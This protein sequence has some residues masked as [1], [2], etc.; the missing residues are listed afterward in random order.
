MERYLTAARVVS[1]LGGRQPA[2]GRRPRRSTACRP[3]LQQH[4]RND[5]L[6]F[7]TR[8]GTLIRHV[9]PLDAEYDLKVVGQQRPRRAAVTAAARDHHRRRPLKVFTLAAARGP[10]DP[11]ARSPAVRTTSASRSSHGRSTSSSRCAN[12]S[13]IRT[14]RPAPAVR[15]VQMP[16]VS[17]GHRSPVHTTRP[18]PATRRAGGGFSRATPKTTARGNRAAPRPSSTARAAR[19]SAARS[20]LRTSR[21][22]STSIRRAAPTGSF[23]AGIEFALRRLLVSPEFLYRIEADPAHAPLS[24]TPRHRGC[25][26]SSA[27]LPHQRLR[28]GLAAVVLPLEQH[29]RRRAARCG[30]AGHAQEIPPCSSGRCAGC[31]PTRARRLSPSNFGGQWLLVRNLRHDPARRDLRAATSTRRCARACS[32]R[33]SSSSTASCARIAACSS[34]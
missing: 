10:D 12:R 3:E 26:R 21:C 7:G 28:A 34:C 18:G 17:S 24:A 29:S 14:R 19:V 32:A 23:D 31:W 6:P 11:R 30:G 25:R 2:A 5:D 20:R 15:P 27:G 8:G 16:T 1:R 4:D 33:P 9:F 13:R 22:C